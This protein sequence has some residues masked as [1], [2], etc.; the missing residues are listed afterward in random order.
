MMMFVRMLA[1][2]LLVLLTLAPEHLF[3]DFVKMDVQLILATIVVAIMVIYDVYTGFILALGLIIL[4]Y[5]LYGGMMLYG[6][7]DEARKL[8][9]MA[10][11][12]TRYVTPEHLHDAQS[13]VVDGPGNNTEIIGITGV[14]GEP[15][16]GAQGL[17]KTM[18][19]YENPDSQWSM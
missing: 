11:L 16:Y 18:P 12:V 10:N 13:N 17:D 19:G 14:Y 15:V 9:P 6:R 8:G 1:L 2:V 7:G 4:Y 5:R 3:V